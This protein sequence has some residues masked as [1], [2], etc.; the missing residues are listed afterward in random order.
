MKVVQG[1]FPNFD[2]GEYFFYQ[3][4]GLQSQLYSAQ[5]QNI[6]QI[7]LGVPGATMGAGCEHGRI[8]RHLGIPPLDQC[9]KK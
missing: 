5:K 7:G 4:K 9:A 8:E 2:H 6:R 1:P 3:G